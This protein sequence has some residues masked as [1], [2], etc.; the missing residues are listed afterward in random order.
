MSALSRPFLP[1]SFLGGPEQHLEKPENGFFKAFLSQIYSDLL[2]PPSLRPPSFA[3]CWESPKNDKKGQNGMDSPI[4]PTAPK[5]QSSQGQSSAFSALC[6]IRISGVPHNYTRG[7]TNG[8][9]SK[10]CVFQSG[11][12]RGWSGSAKAEGTK[13]HYKTLVCVSGIFV[14]PLNGVFL[15]R[16]PR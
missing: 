14:V 7:V 13:M 2:T 3:A 5:F 10:R 16:K 1:F 8:V 15:C 6:P 11:V 12:F 4:S 9:F